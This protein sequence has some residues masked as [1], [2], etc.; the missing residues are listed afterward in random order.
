MHIVTQYDLEIF[1]AIILFPSVFP[2]IIYQ[3]SWRHHAWHPPT[4]SK[5]CFFFIFI[6]MELDHHSVTRSSLWSCDFHLGWWQGARLG[7]SRIFSTFSIIKST[8]LVNGDP[9]MDLCCAHQCHHCHQYWPSPSLPWWSRRTWPKTTCLPSSHWVLAV[10]RKNWEPLVFGPALAIES[11][12]GESKEK[13]SPSL[14]AHK[15]DQ[16]RLNCLYCVCSVLFC[17]FLIGHVLE[18]QN[19]LRCVRHKDRT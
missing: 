18:D 15:Y 16:K 7:A 14:V 5:W 8:N 2:I 4:T 11:T 13:L 6:W 17:L 12:P 19:P 1:C 10:H 3:P 9:P